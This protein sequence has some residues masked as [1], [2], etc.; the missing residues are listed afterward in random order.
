MGD[1]KQLDS[2]ESPVDEIKCERYQT[3]SKIKCTKEDNNQNK[4][5]LLN[6]ADRVHK[7][8]C[9]WC[10]EN[11]WHNPSIERRR[12]V[13]SGNVY[14][15]EPTNRRLEEDNSTV[16]EIAASGA[17]CVLAFVLFHKAHR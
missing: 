4:V 3:G 11:R 13:S 15:S 8:V 1:D 7:P 12:L 14:P 17:L 6:K 9:D 16:S 5:D 2:V 10:V